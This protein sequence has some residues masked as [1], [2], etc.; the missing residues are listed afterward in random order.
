MANKKKNPWLQFFC[1][2]RLTSR[3]NAREYYDSTHHLKNRLEEK[4]RQKADSSI[5]R[6][7]FLDLNVRVI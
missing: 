4:I 6:S 3:I 5:M 7:N 2:I 1:K